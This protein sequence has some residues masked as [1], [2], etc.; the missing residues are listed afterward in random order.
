MLTLLENKL[1][2]FEMQ[3]GNIDS[4]LFERYYFNNQLR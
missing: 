2:S 4:N 3:K 1:T